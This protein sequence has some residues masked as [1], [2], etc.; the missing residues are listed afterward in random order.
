M[1][2]ATAV[3]LRVDEHPQLQHST[4]VPRGIIP[5]LLSLLTT[6]SFLVSLQCTLKWSYT[7][8]FIT[9]AALPVI[10]LVCTMVAALL[11]KLKNY[12][13]QEFQKWRRK[14]LSPPTEVDSLYGL[15]FACFY[16]VY[17]QVC[18]YGYCRSLLGVAPHLRV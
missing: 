10:V 18:A 15:C 11:I 3:H 9:I 4:V 8:K 2:K 17:L 16:Y 5:A 14:D 7:Y 13:N 12:A 1:A 6:A